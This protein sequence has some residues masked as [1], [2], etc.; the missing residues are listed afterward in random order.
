MCRTCVENV[1]GVVFQTQNSNLINVFGSIN[2]IGWEIKHSPD[3]VFAVAAEGWLFEEAW[4]ELVI[5]H[6]VHIF[7]L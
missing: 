4:N 7:L 6:I 5:L 3:K 2:G 1:G